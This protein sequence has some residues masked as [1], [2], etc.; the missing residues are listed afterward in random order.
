MVQL[1]EPTGSETEPGLAGFTNLADI[2]RERLARAGAQ[3]EANA[4]SVIASKPIDVGFRT[5]KLAP[6][7]FSKWTLQSDVGQSALEQHLF[8]IRDSA[9]DSAQQADLLVELLIKQGFS[10]S[11]QIHECEIAN[12][13]IYSVGDGLVLAYVDEMVKPSLESLREVIEEKP[14]KLVVLEDAFHGDDE[15]KTNL[16]QLC[17]SK[18]VELWTA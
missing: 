18:N 11:E 3:L 5:Y 16:A 6:S 13:R 9:Q 17:K 1:P 10:L 4:D 8:E 12:L 15:L 14:S 7:G 2:C